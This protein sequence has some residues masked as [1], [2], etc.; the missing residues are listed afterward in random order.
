VP[1]QADWNP[2]EKL[3]ELRR[4]S[5]TTSLDLKMPEKKIPSRQMPS[6][7]PA[8]YNKET[9]PSSSQA[10]TSHVGTSSSTSGATATP[11]FTNP[12]F[13]SS[14]S[15]AKA[16]EVLSPTEHGSRQF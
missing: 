15:D 11:Q 8:F 2:E 6:T 14:S 3:E 13:S 16:E 1:E 9:A 4:G 12:G 5:L 7:A 10:T